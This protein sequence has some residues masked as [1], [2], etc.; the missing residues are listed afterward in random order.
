MCLMKRNS[1]GLIAALLAMIM[2]LLLIPIGVLAADN[3][4]TKSGFPKVDSSNPEILLTVQFHQTEARKTLELVNNF[5]TGDEAYYA[6]A[7]GSGPVYVKGLKPLTYSYGLETIAMQRAVEYAAWEVLGAKADS[8]NPHIRPNGTEAGSARL[9]NGAELWGEN[10]G[11]GMNVKK[12]ANE[13]ISSWKEDGLPYAKQ[14]HRRNMLNEELTHMGVAYVTYEGK[15]FWAMALGYEDDSQPTVASD[16]SEK[17]YIEVLD[18]FKNL[19]ESDSDS[20]IDLPDVPL[21]RVIYDS[22]AIGESADWILYDDGELVLSGSGKADYM[23]E[24]G[25]YAPWPAGRVKKV[26]VEPGITSIGFYKFNGCKNLESITLPTTVTFIGQYAFAGCSGLKELVLPDS[27][28]TVADNAFDGCT[29]LETLTLSSGMSAVKDRSFAGCTSL[30]TIYFPANITE[31]VDGAFSNCPNIKDVY[32]EGS[33]S[34]WNA[35][36]GNVQSVDLWS[37]SSIHFGKEDPT[38]K[39]AEEPTSQKPS[40]EPTSQ[41]PSEEPTSQKPSEE[42]TS[43]KPSEEPTSQKPSEKP[44]SQ[45]PSEEPTSQKPSEKPTSQKPFEEPSSQKTSEEPS[46]TTTTTKKTAEPTPVTPVSK[47][48]GLANEV[49]EDGN[50]YYYTDGKIDR[51]HTGVDQNKNGWWSVEN[52]KVNFKAQG[53]YQNKYGWWKC[54][55]GKVTFKETGIFKNEYGWWRVENSKVNFEAN[56]IYQNPYGWWKTKNGKVTFNENG[57]FQNENGWWKVKNSKVDF[58]FTGIAKNKNGSWYLKNGKVDFSKNGKVTYNGQR[59]EL[60]NGKAQ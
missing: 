18:K 59:Y 60:K 17:V 3:T 56:G 2:V 9:E 49:A 15:E 11:Y 41:K 34:E 20:P 47:F 38:E 16:V 31:V 37:A 43:Q 50:W 52:G 25:E 58:S 46:G 8:S 45:K 42:P 23:T 44:T 4:Q 26:T 13:A 36:I 7:D 10:L 29:S 32:Y 40:E 35:I 30:K 22:G 28:E 1:R 19:G 55:N 51:T 5:R 27:V 39:P 21:E 54:S 57:I 48:T 24:D 53:I 12:T 6:N 14:G 33:P